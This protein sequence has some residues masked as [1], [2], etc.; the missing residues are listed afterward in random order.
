MSLTGFGD[1]IVEIFGRA[2]DKLP[3]LLLTFIVGYLVMKV[4]LMIVG[5]LIKVS[6]AKQALKDILLSVIGLAL[7]L[8]LIAAMLQQVG[9]TQLAFALS[10][11]VAIAGLAVTAGASSLVQDLISGVFL[12]QDPDF[13]VGDELKVG[14]I[15]GIIEKMDARKIRLRDKK[16]MLHVLPNSMF[17]KASWIVVQKRGGQRS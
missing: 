16:G 12:A 5:G 10:G 13:N 15:E 2:W 1:Q 17:D 3:Q 9:L 7:W 4:I 11:F 6:R 8:L 14:E